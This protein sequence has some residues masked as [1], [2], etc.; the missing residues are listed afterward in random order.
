MRRVGFLLCSVALTASFNL[1]QAQN[2]VITISSDSIVPS[3]TKGESGFIVNITQISTEQTGNYTLPPQSI[4]GNRVVNAEKQLNGEYIDPDFDEPW[5]N[6][7]D[8][9]ADEGWSYF[10][11]RV[12]YVNQ[13]QSAFEGEAEHGNFTSANGFQDEEIPGIPGWNDSIDGIVGEYLTLLQLDAGAYTLGVNS[14]DGFR[15]TI[16]AN[17]NDILTQKIGVFEGVRVAADSIFDIV[18]EKAGLYP[19]RVLWFENEGEASIEIFSMVDGQKVLINDPDVEGSIK[20]YTPKGATVG[21]SITERDAS[22]GRA[23]VISIMPAPGKKRVES[24]SPIE[25]V[26]ENGSATEVD[27]SSVKLTLNGKDV[28]ANVS[29]SGGIV[30]ISYTGGLAGGAN[31]AILS[32]KES[33]GLERAAEWSFEAYEEGAAPAGIVWTGANGT[34]VF[35]EGN[36]DLSNS[37]VTVIDPNVSIDADVVILNATVDIPQ[38][39]AQQS[40]Q[41]ASDFT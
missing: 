32:F 34:D 10:P 38:L 23:A 14:D 35:D 25:V 6:E 41:V 7:A 8:T 33:T 19:F 17:Y 20:A 5:L 2:G 22:T 1:L 12:E 4:H 13:G 28:D 11:I 39:D 24:S 3:S 40:F 31:T 27:Q 9:D 26:I 21:E 15:A 37:S 36:W 18:V 30:T 16:G 29:K